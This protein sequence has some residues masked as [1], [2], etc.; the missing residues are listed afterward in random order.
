MSAIS[1]GRVA[2][3]FSLLLA[4]AACPAD[5]AGGGASRAQAPERHSDMLAQTN[6]ELA[7]WTRPG[8]ALRPVPH[9]GAGKTAPITLSFTHQRGAARLAGFAGCNNYSGQYTIANGL[10][11]VTAPP[12]ST[13]MACANADLARLEQDY[14]AGLTAVTASR[15]DHD[16]RPQRLTLALRSGD[17]L[18][19]ARRADPLAGGQPGAAKLVYVASSKAPCSAGAGRAQ[20]YQVRDSASQPW[21]LWYGD[22]TGF[23][24]QPGIEY[25]LRVVE[26]RD[27]NPPADASGVR[28]V[29]DSVVEQRVAA[30]RPAPAP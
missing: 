22:I 14:L 29:L 7:R 12:V 26:V 27:P 30:P 20:C 3:S 4:L 10:L 24:F 25:R 17:V 21:L 6:W 28:W 8:G 1:P 2:L 15:L 23:A 5:P 19:F 16:T 9:G 18:D 13:R 11:I